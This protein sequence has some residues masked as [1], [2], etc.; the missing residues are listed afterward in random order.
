MSES[1]NSPELSL[2]ARLEGQGGE[3]QARVLP[4][5]GSGDVVALAG[6]DCFVVAPEGAGELAAGGWVDVLPR[7]G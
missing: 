3:V 5:Q 2:P 4:W 7:N 6:S 1:E